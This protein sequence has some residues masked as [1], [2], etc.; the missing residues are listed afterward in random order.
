MCA[1]LKLPADAYDIIMSLLEVQVSIIVTDNAY[2]TTRI[3]REC[4]QVCREAK[5]HYSKTLQASEYADFIVSIPKIVTLKIILSQGKTHEVLT[6]Y[7]RVMD[8]L[9]EVSTLVPKFLIVFPHILPGIVF[10]SNE[11]RVMNVASAELEC[12]KTW[13]EPILLERLLSGIQIKLNF[14]EG[15]LCATNLWNTCPVCKGSG[16]MF[17]N[18]QGNA[19]FALCFVC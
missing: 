3:H 11:I 8:A 9:P 15:E 10:L 19:R 14:P 16:Y 7:K 6:K 18:G 13:L 1:S 4:L 12:V 17:F 5:D 2:T